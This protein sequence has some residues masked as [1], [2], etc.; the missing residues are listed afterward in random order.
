MYELLLRRLATATKSAHIVAA[1]LDPVKLANWELAF[2]ARF[3]N[4]IAGAKLRDRGAKENNESR[5]G[6]NQTAGQPGS[7]RRAGRRV[8]SSRLSRLRGRFKANHQLS[9]IFEIDMISYRPD[10]AFLGSLDL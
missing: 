1:H 2:Y 10:A 6:A 4:V 5:D 8:R 7:A 3:G 9:P